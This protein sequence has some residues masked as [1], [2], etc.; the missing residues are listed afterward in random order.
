MK[1]HNCIE[2]SP[3]HGWCDCGHAYGYLIMTAWQIYTESDDRIA[4]S[5]AR[6]ALIE[7]FGSVKKAATKLKETP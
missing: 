1:S 7:V 6:Y 3:E 2:R 5:K 4:K